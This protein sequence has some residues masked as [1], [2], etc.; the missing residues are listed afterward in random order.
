MLF[1]VQIIAFYDLFSFL[2]EAVFFPVRSDLP[3]FLAIHLTQNLYRMFLCSLNQS[4]YFFNIIFRKSLVAFYFCVKTWITT[5]RY[6]NVTFNFAFRRFDFAHLKWSRKAKLIEL[7]RHLNIIQYIL[8][9]G[10][11]LRIWTKIY[12]DIQN[13]NT[14]GV[15]VGPRSHKTIRQGQNIDLSNRFIFPLRSLDLVVDQFLLITWLIAI[16]CVGVG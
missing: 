5:I 6:R 15:Y 7:V 12:G 9:T 4:I 16:D 2:T 14:S 11:Y 1:W 13:S 8:K 10:E 3:T